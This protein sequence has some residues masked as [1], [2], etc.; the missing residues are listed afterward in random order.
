ML[1]D[2]YSC[3]VLSLAPQINYMESLKRDHTYVEK[4]ILVANSLDT[5]WPHEWGRIVPMSLVWEAM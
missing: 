2:S 1:V 4:V 5:L 3:A